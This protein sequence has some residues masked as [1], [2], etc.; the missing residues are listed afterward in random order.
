MFTAQFGI[1]IAAAFVRLRAYAYTHDKRLSDLA[2]DIVTRRP[3]LPAVPDPSP[4]WH[5]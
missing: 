3:R 2:S 4:E 5:A 1:G